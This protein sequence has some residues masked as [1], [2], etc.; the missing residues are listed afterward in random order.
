MS[1]TSKQLAYLGALLARAGWA[2]STDRA[3]GSTGKR[4]GLSMRERG[5]AIRDLDRATISQWIDR[6]LTEGR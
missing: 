4:W 2:T 6:L 5:M 3:I 1:A